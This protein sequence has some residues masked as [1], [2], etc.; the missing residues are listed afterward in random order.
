MLELRR[1]FKGEVV[2]LERVP[3]SRPRVACGAMTASTEAVPRQQTE[4]T[5]QLDARWRERAQRAQQAALPPRAAIAVSCSAPL[6]A[7]GLGRHLQRDRR[8]ARRAGRRRV[9]ISGSTR[10]QQRDSPARTRSGCA[11]HALLA[12]LL[13]RCAR[14]AV[15]RAFARAP[16]SSTSTP[17]PPRSCPPREHLIAFNGQALR[18][19]ARGAR[20]RATS[21]SRS[22]PR[23]RTCAALARQHDARAP[24]A[25]RSRARG[26]THLLARNLAEYARADRIYVASRYIRESFLHE[27]FPR[28]A[29]AWTSR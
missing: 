27:G 17:T 13:A 12:R 18:Q 28:G 22:S 5:V 24:R 8:R 20:A 25:T 23:T 29:A 9:C 15:S 2:A 4:P 7:G 16:S 11:R 19:F 14:A 1:R 6:G 21:R 3:G 26:P 10:A